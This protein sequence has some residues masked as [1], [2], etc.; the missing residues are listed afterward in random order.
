[1]YN[2]TIKH[3]LHEYRLVWICSVLQQ[4]L[5]KWLL[6]IQA[7]SIQSSPW[8]TV[9]EVHIGTYNISFL[10]IFISINFTIIDALQLMDTKSIYARNVG[11]LTAKKIHGHHYDTCLCILVC[12]VSQHM[13]T[14]AITMCFLHTLE[15][16]CMCFNFTEKIPPSTSCQ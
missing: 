5:H 15:N 2:L 1:M 14:V 13:L 10:P 8:E 12:F 7:C 4:Q 9:N 3:M 16:P 11:C 6:F